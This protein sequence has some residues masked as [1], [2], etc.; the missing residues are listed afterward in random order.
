M[1]HD[2]GQFVL[3]CALYS[4]KIILRYMYHCEALLTEKREQLSRNFC[5][6]REVFQTRCFKIQV[7]YSSTVSYS[8]LNFPKFLDM[9]MFFFDI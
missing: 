6:F 8:I 4:C 1:L 3:L 5:S 9:N 7:I 2:R